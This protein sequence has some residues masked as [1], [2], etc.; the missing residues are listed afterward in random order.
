[1]QAP[2]A[3]VIC[4]DYWQDASSDEMTPLVLNCSGEMSS[5]ADLGSAG[6]KEA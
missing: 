2:M 4:K 5:S 3:V 1:M 6:D